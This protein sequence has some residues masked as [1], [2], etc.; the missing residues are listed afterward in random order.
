[1]A[2]R[3]QRLTPDCRQPPDLV[4]DFVQPTP[5]TRLRTA[6]VQDANKGHGLSGGNVG[7]ASNESEATPGDPSQIVRLPPVLPELHQHAVPVHRQRLLAALPERR[8]QLGRTRI[9]PA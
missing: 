5:G 2:D 1:M 7:G 4:H 3:R 9:R 8:D 6:L